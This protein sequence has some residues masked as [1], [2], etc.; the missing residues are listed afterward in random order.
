[1]REK[2]LIGEKD[3]LGFIENVSAKSNTIFLHKLFFSVNTSD[4]GLFFI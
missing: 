2:H 4:L 3:T 1:M